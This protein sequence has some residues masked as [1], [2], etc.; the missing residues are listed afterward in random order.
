LYKWITFLLDMF[1]VIQY[2]TNTHHT[3]DD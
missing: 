1:L 2:D 3:Q